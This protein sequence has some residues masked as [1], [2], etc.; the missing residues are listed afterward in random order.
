MIMDID[1]FKGINDRYGHYIGDE[2]LVKVTK[3]VLDL[4]RIHDEAARMSSD[5][6]VL[7]LPETDAAGGMTIAERIRSAI[8]GQIF[9]LSNNTEV[10]ITCSFGLAEFDPVDANFLH[11]YREADEALYKA[12]QMGK[13]RIE[14]GGF[15]Q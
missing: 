1:N 14:I 5:E 13:N 11:L 6:Y 7:L 2:V 12:K 10:S 9:L 8:E 4:A 3:M 15:I